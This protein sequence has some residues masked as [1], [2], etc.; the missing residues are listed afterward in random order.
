MIIILWI[1]T[2]SF[3]LAVLAMLGA[4]LWRHPSF[5]DSARTL[6]D[7]FR[8]ALKDCGWTPK[9]RY[10]V[11][12]WKWEVMNDEDVCE[13]CLER[14]SWPPMDIADWMQAGIPRTPEAE[15]ECGEEC[16]CRL[17]RYSP[18]RS[19]KKYHGRT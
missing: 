6:L 11:E 19:Q 1:I 2:V 8:T 17:V 9:R 4:A 7:G 12:L 16:R 3:F 10:E 18:K 5:R 15:T 14:A 13:D